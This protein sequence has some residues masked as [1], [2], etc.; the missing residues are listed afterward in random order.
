[1][2]QEALGKNK[3]TLYNHFI[4]FFATVNIFQGLWYGLKV[5]FGMENFL[6]FCF[7]LIKIQTNVS[8]FFQHLKNWI[9]QTDLI[10]KSWPKECQPSQIFLLFQKE[11]IKLFI[12]F[13]HENKRVP[14]DE[15][16]GKNYPE[17][18]CWYSQPSTANGNASFLG[19]DFRSFCLREFSVTLKL[20]ASLFQIFR[21][22][23]WWWKHSGVLM[24]A[25]NPC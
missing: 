15:F 25:N 3:V 10:V 14:L 6:L 1:M 13:L 9:L 8:W 24:L 12:N 17:V 5:I 22:N 21:V 16:F 4:T 18:C 7:Y 11:G 23:N 19:G 20:P 2:D